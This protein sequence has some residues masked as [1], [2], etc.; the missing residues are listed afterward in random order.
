[1]AGGGEVL[2]SSLSGDGSDPVHRWHA[3]AVP[4]DPSIVPTAVPGSVL[5]AFGLDDDA[6][7]EPLGAGHIHRTWLAAGDTVIQWLNGRVFADLDR[8]MEN[9]ERITAHLLRRRPQWADRSPIRTTDGALVAVDPSTGRWRAQPF[10][11]GVVPG[12]DAQPRLISG[13]PPSRSDRS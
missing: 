1:M 4:A 7:V 3:G 9:R 12:H 11:P 8:V 6:P 5:A 2:I 10:V 13:R